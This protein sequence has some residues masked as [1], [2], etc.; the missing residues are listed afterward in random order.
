MYSQ[1][2]YISQGST[3]KEQLENIQSTLDA[4]CEWIQLRFKNAV[5]K[6]FTIVALQ[7]RKLCE[8]YNATFIIN[9]NVELAKTIDASGVHLGLQ[10]M[11]VLQARTI[12]GENK[13]IGATANTLNDVL[14]HINEKCDYIGL[15]PFRFTSTKTN[16]SPVLGIG[17]YKI[18]M[19]EISKKKIQ[20]PIY[21][22]GGISIDD[23]TSIINTGLYGVAVSGAITNHSNKKKLVQTFNS[24][25]HEKVIN[26]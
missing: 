22:I 15:G 5:E 10:D 12:L 24:L 26:C 16:L 6:D 20:I 4:G 25:L 18:I 13:I 11:P 2:Q 7:V 8:N 14:K 3:A 17:G 23:V 21:A 1:L 19:D 9:D